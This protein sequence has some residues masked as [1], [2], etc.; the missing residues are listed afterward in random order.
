MSAFDEVPARSAAPNVRWPADQLHSVLSDYLTAAQAAA[1]LRVSVRTLTRWNGLRVGPPRSF[2]GRKILYR[3]D[4][5]RSW[6]QRQEQTLVIARR[7]RGKGA[8]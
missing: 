8:R 5:L 3:I 2:V 7:S 6:L 4:A 1:E